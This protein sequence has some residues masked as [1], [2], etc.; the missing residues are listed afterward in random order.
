MYKNPS[1]MKIVVQS[2]SHVQLFK[3]HGQQYARLPCPS[4]SP[5]VCS[6]SCPLSRWCHLAIS[7]SVASFSSPQSFPESGSFPMS[8][9]F[10]S[11]G[12]SIG[13]STSTSVLPMNT[14]DKNWPFPVLWPLLSFQIWWHIECSTFTASSFRIWNSSTAIPSPP[15]ALFVVMLPKAHLT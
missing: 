10:T 6:N 8:Q 4:L 12:Q 14:Q 11:G 13:V 2:L 15:L 9:L 3:P 1:I 7:S 5:E